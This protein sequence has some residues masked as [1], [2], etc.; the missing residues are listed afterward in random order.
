MKNLRRIF[1]T[2]LALGLIYFSLLN[3]H[4]VD[5]VW[6][7]QGDIYNVP[8]YTVLFLGIFLGLLTAIWGTGFK[9]VKDFFDKKRVER[10]VKELETELDALRDKE[11]HNTTNNKTNNSLASEKDAQ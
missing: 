8:L 2:L 9:R 11:P 10:R 6:S 3:R 5:V 1:A 7:L 4:T